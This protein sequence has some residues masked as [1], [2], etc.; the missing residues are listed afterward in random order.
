MELFADLSFGQAI[1][2]EDIYAQRR[3]TKKKVIWEIERVYWLKNKLHGEFVTDYKS[4]DFAL[5]DSSFVVSE[6]DFSLQT[7]WQFLASWDKLAGFKADFFGDSLL[8]ETKNFVVDSAQLQGHLQG[9]EFFASLRM[10]DSLAEVGFRGDLFE[11]SCFVSFQSQEF[12]PN[13]VLKQK[14]R[15]LPLCRL[16]SKGYVFEKTLHSQIDIFLQDSYYGLVSGTF[17]SQLDYDFEQGELEIG[18]RSYK[19][20]F[21]YN[22]FDLDLHAKGS[23]DSLEVDRFVINQK[24]RGRFLIT[25]ED[26]YRCQ[27]YLVASS[28]SLPLWQKYFTKK[29]FSQD[30]DGKLSTS[31]QLK[32]DGS[33][34]FNLQGKGLS[35][36]NWQ[37]VDADLLLSGSLDSLQVK[38]M[39]MRVA[40]DTIGKGSGAVFWDSTLQIRGVVDV[41]DLDL[42]KVQAEGHRDWRGVVC[43]QV[44]MDYQKGSSLFSGEMSLQD[45]GY[46]SLSF[47]DGDLRFNQE[48]EQFVMERC[49]FVGE[50]ENKAL[51][52]K[53]RLGYN[54]LSGSVYPSKAQMQVSYR[55]DFLRRLA[56]FVPF[57]QEPKSQAEIDLNLWMSDDGLRVKSGSLALSGGKM[58]IKGQPQKID[59]MEIDLSIADDTLSVRRFTAQAGKGVLH[60]SNDFSKEEESLVLG[61]LNLGKIYFWSSGK[62]MK[63]YFPD[64]MDDK[65]E[66]TFSVSGV[67][68]NEKAFVRGPAESMLISMEFHISDVQAMFPKNSKNLLNL[69]TQSYTFTKKKVRKRL[70]FFVEMVLVFDDNVYYKTYPFN[71]LVDKG[72]Y[73]K[74]GYQKDEKWELEMGELSSVSGDMEILSSVLSAKKVKLRVSKSNSVLDLD[75]EFEATAVDG[76]TVSLRLKS[77]DNSNFSIINNLDMQLV[78]TDKDLTSDLEII[79]SL[80]YDISGEENDLSSGDQSVVN[81]QVIELVGEGVQSQVFDIF[82]SPVENRLQR[83][84]RLDMFRIKMNVVQNILQDYDNQQDISDEQTKLEGSDIFLNQMKILLGKSLTNRLFIVSELKVEE[85]DDPL[86]ENKELLLN[87]KI[88]FKYILPYDFRFQYDYNFSQD[89]EKNLYELNLKKSID[90]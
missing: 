36:G 61:N 88:G 49:E 52:L 15:Y 59:D 40:K 74:F 60:I 19:S 46:K 20:T 84:L 7:S 35:Y 34:D 45:F 5:F 58:R 62:K 2:L 13:L 22:L 48:Q 51:S 14:N 50:K 33:L 68:E 53:G 65:A 10:K 32:S 77:I 4:F 81:S 75:G 44:R 76:N 42:L 86:V 82:I 89:S 31:L 23:F 90:F 41:C 30:L 85:S 37:G 1:G 24:M 39:E 26:N 11:D 57:I 71:L 73:L 55:G 8:V 79:S 80:K 21:N 64:Y 87:Q 17:G 56:D 28:L 78:S 16:S 67:G 25:K 27:G 6:K 18:L 66:G 38:R 83:A 72:G 9:S 12:D 3:L 47:T 70:P 63:F 69:I 54:F 29:I 43:G